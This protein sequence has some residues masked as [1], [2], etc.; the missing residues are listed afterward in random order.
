M[1]FTKGKQKT[2]GKKKGTPNKTTQTAKELVLLAIDSQT[3]QFDNVMT[4][5][6]VED[7]KE[8]ARLMVRMFDFVLPRQLDLKSDGEKLLPPVINVRPFNPD[9]DLA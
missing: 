8:W 9:A 5:L 6:Q 4:R 1:A 2:G 7:P 3:Q